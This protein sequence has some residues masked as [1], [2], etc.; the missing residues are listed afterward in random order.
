MQT[1]WVAIW[2]AVHESYGLVVEAVK[3]PFVPRL[4]DPV[5]LAVRQQ[6]EQPMTRVDGV[7]VNFQGLPLTPP[8]IEVLDGRKLGPSDVFIG[9]Y[10]LPSVRAGRYIKFMFQREMENACIARNDVLL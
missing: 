7:F 10:A 3:K 9:R 2:L 4:G 8:G 1:V 6:R 5:P